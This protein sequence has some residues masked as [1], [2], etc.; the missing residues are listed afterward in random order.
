M[1]TP[2]L[3]DPVM[4]VE[5]N[6]LGPLD[7]GVLVEHGSWARAHLGVF[8]QAV[9]HELAALGRPALGNGKGGGRH[10][11]DVVQQLQDGQRRLPWPGKGKPQVGQF[12]DGQAQR[13]D[14]GLHGVAV[15]LY[16]LRLEVSR[17]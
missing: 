1:S 16:P 8:D 4:K 15:A 7:E 6:G 10:A 5:L 17:A 9:L 11:D 14:V 3:T 12:R 13:P 2:D